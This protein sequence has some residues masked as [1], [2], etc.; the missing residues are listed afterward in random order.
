VILRK[1][2]RERG[3]RGEPFVIALVSVMEA[4]RLEGLD[5]GEGEQAVSGKRGESCDIHVT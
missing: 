3:E 5:G 2:A 4:G 1:L